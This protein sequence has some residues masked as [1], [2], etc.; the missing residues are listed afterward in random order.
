MPS[1]DKFWDRAARNYDAGS[2]DHDANYERRLEKLKSLLKPTDNVLDFACATGEIGLGV[3]PFVARVHGIDVSE[4][5]IA[6]A[7]KKVA[8]RGIN[9]ASFGQTDVFDP[10]IKGQSFSVILAFNI[11]HLLE[12]A[13]SVLARLHDILAPGGLLI[14]STPCL[15]N[16]NIFFRAMIRFGASMKLMPMVHSFK[17]S[18]I[19]RL[20]SE[21]KFEIL[22]SKP[23]D[24]KN[25]VRW[26]LARK[27]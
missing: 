6:L 22:E 7:N 13:P 18:E 25:T 11:F 26:I 10:D 21:Q 24:E 14:S 23:W 27:S 17:A 19:E 1:Y 4:G 2:Q 15:G 8:E 9:N 16:G 3:T 20:V 5:M 12:D